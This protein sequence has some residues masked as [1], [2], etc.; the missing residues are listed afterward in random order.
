MIH[1]TLGRIAAAAVAHW[2]SPIS[3]EVRRDRLTYL[4]PLELRGIERG[5]RTIEREG[6]VATSWNSGWHPAARPSSL[7]R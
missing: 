1:G 7:R 5:C 3:R 2:L 4:S 6:F